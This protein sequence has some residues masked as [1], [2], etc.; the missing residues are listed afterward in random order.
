MRTRWARPRRCPV[1]ETAAPRDG[2][3]HP[4]RPGTS[5]PHARVVGLSRPGRRATRRHPEPVLRVE[6]WPVGRT[7]HAALSQ[8]PAHPDD[9]RSEDDDEPDGRE[10]GLLG[11]IR[12]R[13]RCRAAGLTLEV[14]DRAPCPPPRTTCGSPAGTPTPVPGGGECGW[15]GP[16]P[17]SA[18]GRF[19]GPYAVM[20][21]CSSAGRGSVRLWRQVG[22]APAGPGKSCPVVSSAWFQREGFSG[23]ARRAK[24]VL[25]GASAVGVFSNR[26]VV[27]SPARGRPVPCGPWCQSRARRLL[28]ASPEGRGSMKL[29]RNVSIASVSSPWQAASIAA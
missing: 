9:G 14:I 15:P 23:R 22:P 29:C 10:H 5:P 17:L 2:R 1:G 8:H 24:T 13:V 7:L 28:R 4:P 21:K 12:T 16:K 18:V 20:R 11:D 19:G 26:V 27:P 3:Y 6:S 25:T